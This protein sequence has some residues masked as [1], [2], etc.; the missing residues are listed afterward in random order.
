[1]E[2]PIQVE[3][4]PTL[5]SLCGLREIAG[6]K[7][8]TKWIAVVFAMALATSARA[9]TPIPVHHADVMVH[10]G[11]Y[12]CGP[13]MTRVGDSCVPKTTARWCARWHGDVCVRWY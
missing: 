9:M 12:A 3:L 11:I 1:M 6:E 7:A 2:G 10:T 4:F 5:A 8:M 13:G